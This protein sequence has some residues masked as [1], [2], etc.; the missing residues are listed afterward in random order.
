MGPGGAVWVKKTDYKK[1]CETVPSSYKP[2][3]FARA[4]KPY[5]VR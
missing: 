2:L 3:N 1:S 5:A 4:N